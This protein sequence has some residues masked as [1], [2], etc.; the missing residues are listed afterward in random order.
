LQ[1]E[2]HITLHLNPGMLNCLCLALLSYSLQVHQRA[3]FIIKKKKKTFSHFTKYERKSL[4]HNITKRLF[5]QSLLYS[6]ALLL[7]LLYCKRVKMMFFDHFTRTVLLKK[8]ISIVYFSFHYHTSSFFFFKCNT[9]RESP[10]DSG[11]KLSYSRATV[12][13]SLAPTLQ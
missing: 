1:N 5:T 8:L 7:A 10:E 4:Q 11:F 3:L 2:F 9:P 13:Q 6:T 12:L